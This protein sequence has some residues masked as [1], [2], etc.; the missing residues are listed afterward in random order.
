MP[1]QLTKT[2]F[3]EGWQCANL[4]WWKVHEPDA[5]ELEMS[6]ALQDL[7]AQGRQVGEMARERFPG[8]VLIDLPHE[9]T[10]E[11]L[12]ATQAALDR[13][14]PAIFEGAFDTDGV[15]IAADV[16]RREDD[17]FALIEVK[18]STKV[19]DEHIPDVA[20]Q[21]HVLRANGVDVRRVE[22]MH[23]NKEYRHPNDG[24]L[25]IREDVTAQVLDMLDGVPHRIEEQLAMLSDDFPN[26]GMGQQCAGMRD[27][28]FHRRCWP[29]DRGHVLELSGKGVRKALELMAE[30][31]DNI[32][33]LPPDYKLSEVNRR[34]KQALE[35][36]EMVVEPELG[37]VLESMEHPIGFLDFETV[38]RAIPVWNGLGPWG[39]VPVQFSYH[40]ERDAG[41]YHHVEWLADGQDDPRE[42]LAIALVESCRRAG[43]I[44][45]YTGFESRQLRHL[46]EAVPHLAEELGD[47]DRRLFDLHKVVKQ[48]VYHPDFAGSFSIKSVLPALVPELS[49]DDLAIAEG[50]TASAEIA[51]M[52][53]TPGAF[54]DGERDKLRQ[55]LLAY[56]KLDTWAMVKLL[57]R[58]EQVAGE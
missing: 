5:P 53:L 46:Q 50:L 12:V 41:Q 29:D 4:L 25:F 1:H 43:H 33:D 28:P 31:I 20:L 24:E 58:L 6:P 57:E 11:R 44:V 56:C 21:T 3:V 17:G 15:F 8:G 42:A 34:Q 37:G 47:I 38:A 55:D 52:M 26:L 19:K 14:V 48:H 27:C 13:G 30:G 45:V 39:A 49:Y 10:E 16:L 35:Q 32:R 18:S 2:R 22:L 40:E 9:A 23:L 54:A 7:F 36:N 51:R